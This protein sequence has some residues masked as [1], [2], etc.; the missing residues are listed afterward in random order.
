MINEINNTGKHGVYD[1]KR[2]KPIL[3]IYSAVLSPINLYNMCN[4]GRISCELI[5]PK[6]I[7]NNVSVILRCS[8][9]LVE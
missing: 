3:V 4:V 2:D 9:L 1:G 7:F 5:E 8:V 6:A